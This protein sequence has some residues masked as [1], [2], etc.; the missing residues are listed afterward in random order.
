MIIG[1]I[2]KICFQ[3]MTRMSIDKCAYGGMRWPGLQIAGTIVDDGDI[4]P[5]ATKKLRQCI[6]L[7]HSTKIVGT[8][9]S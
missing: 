8:M 3:T 6:T 9:K 5:L 4:I 7:E 2:P 1:K